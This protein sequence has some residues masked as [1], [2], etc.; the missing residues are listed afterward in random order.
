MA[1]ESTTGEL[2]WLLDDLVARLGGTERA[3]VLSSDGLLIGR[4]N[5]LDTE[6]AEHLS[7]LCSGLQS[8]A[9]A[10]GKQFD[11]GAVHQTM[12]EMEHGVLLV[13]EAGTGACLALL[14]AADADLGMLAYEMNLLVK[15]VGGV[16]SAHPR[17]ADG[18]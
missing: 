8:L 11:G 9:R 4:S 10:T 17:T 13:T 2:N 18:S 3:V 7:A 14:A 6:D 16:L 12:V 1:G 5:T 15:Q